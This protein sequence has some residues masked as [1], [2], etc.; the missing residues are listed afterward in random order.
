MEH[1]P[2]TPDGDCIACSRCV[3]QREDRSD[4]L[5]DDVVAGWT[6]FDRLYIYKGVVYIVAD[7]ASKVPDVQFIYSKA[8]YIEEGAKAEEARLPTDEDIRVINTLEAKRLFGTGAQIIDGMNVR[9]FSL[10]SAS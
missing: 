8:L 10:A 9:W 7:D 4:K 2:G 6:I 3:A 1:E 5:N